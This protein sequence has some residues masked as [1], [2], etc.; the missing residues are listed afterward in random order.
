VQVHQK[1][2]VNL[3]GHARNHSYLGES[4]VQG[5]PWLNSN[6]E[7]SLSYMR[8]VFVF[9]FLFFVFCFLIKKERK[10]KC[11]TDFK[12][13]SKFIFLSQHISI[14]DGLHPCQLLTTSVF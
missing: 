12:A 2:L 11:Q 14:P 10:K 6:C 13:T 9:C 3:V 4:R 1:L 7:A 5:Q 8:P